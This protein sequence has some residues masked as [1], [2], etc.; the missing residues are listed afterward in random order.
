MQFNKIIRGN[1]RQANTEKELYEVLDA[2][3]LCHVAFTHQGKAMMIPTSYGRKGNVLY[4]HGNSKNFMLN[5]A[6]KNEQ[7]CIS[8]TH[9]DGIVLAKSMFNTSVNYRSAVLFGKCEK[10][11]NPV[12]FMESLKILT[13]NVIPG[14]WDEVELGIENQINM[15]MVVKFTIESSS[16]KI[17]KT[18]PE[19]DED[20]N[21]NEWS[22]HI[23]LKLVPQKPV[24][25]SKRTDHPTISR[26]V[27]D[28]IKK[29]TP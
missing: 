21:T 26:S 8:V 9:L 16:V 10:V 15:L 24:F 11:E 17:R 23:P 27:T 1:Y 13:E 5:E 3:F 2:G 22:G 20:I 19:G 18:G 6:L 7:V 14:R 12:E 28:F 29:H 4:L 25:D